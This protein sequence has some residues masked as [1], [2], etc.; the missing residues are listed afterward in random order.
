MI[1]GFYRRSIATVTRYKWDQQVSPRMNSLMVPASV[2]LAIA[3]VSAGCTGGPLSASP[4]Q[5]SAPDPSS[6]GG[7][8]VPPDLAGDWS[9]T[10]MGV[11]GGTQVIDPIPDIT[12]WAGP[13][14]LNGNDG[15]TDYSAAYTLTGTTLPAGNGIAVGP[16]EVPDVA[17]PDNADEISDYLDILGRT[18]AY[19][20][21]SGKLTLTAGNGDTL[22]FERPALVPTTVLPPPS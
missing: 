17:C 16:V 20:T 9:L 7:S 4:S 1:S 21:V 11:Q 10:T 14:V 6:I 3:I 15:C 22:V 18:T 19:A 13:G 8:F 5:K 12:L 2:L